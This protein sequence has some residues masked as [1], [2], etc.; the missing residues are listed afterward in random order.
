MS[1]LVTKVP[2]SLAE[3]TISFEDGE[4]LLKL[5]EDIRFGNMEIH[6]TSATI[7]RDTVVIRR[8]N[9]PNDP[10]K[11]EK[12][13]GPNYTSLSSA[14]FTLLAAGFN[15][16]QNYWGA[17]P[18][19]ARHVLAACGCIV[20]WDHDEQTQNFRHP[21]H[22]EYGY[23]CVDHE[24]QA[25]VY[26]FNTDDFVLDIPQGHILLDDGCIIPWESKL[27]LYTHEGGPFRHQWVKCPHHS[28]FNHQIVDFNRADFPEEA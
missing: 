11:P 3:S 24:L 19:P 18:L 12:N 17:N 5:R 20:N 1:R 4:L 28:T 23:H 16:V 8:A 2:Q 7:T 21:S 6:I 26:R 14:E 9:I 27:A 25:P 15:M 22:L 13:V 10:L